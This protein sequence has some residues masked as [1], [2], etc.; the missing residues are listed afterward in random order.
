M[1]AGTTIYD[2]YQQALAAILTE[3]ASGRPFGMRV[4]NLRIGSGPILTGTGVRLHP[5]ET[6]LEDKNVDSLMGNGDS[7][8]L[9]L[10]RTHDNPLDRAE[11]SN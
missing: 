4:N 8:W 10:D 5:D 6:V 7:D 9:I 1:I 2:T 11:R 3:W